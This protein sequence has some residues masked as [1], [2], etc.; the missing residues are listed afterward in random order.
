[1]QQPFQHEDGESDASDAS[2]QRKQK[3]FGQELK[4][5]FAAARTEGGPD[6]EF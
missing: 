5:D 1:M 3:R 4:D 2:H 6:G